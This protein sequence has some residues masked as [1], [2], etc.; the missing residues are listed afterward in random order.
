MLIK[1]Q[2]YAIESQRPLLPEPME[3]KTIAR[4][5]MESIVRAL[6]TVQVSTS[7]STSG[8]LDDK[9]NSSQI[10]GCIDCFARRLE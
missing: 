9:D 10:E 5:V 6:I 3:C 2:H 4:T 1:I 8:I 7:P